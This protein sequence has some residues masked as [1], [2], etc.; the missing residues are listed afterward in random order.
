MKNVSL[1]S[2][3]LLAGACATRPATYDYSYGFSSSR[4]PAQNIS[5]DQLVRFGAEMT[6]GSEELL[7]K[8]PTH[9]VVVETPYSHALIQRIEK[10]LRDALGNNAVIS[11]KNFHSHWSRYA[12]SVLFKDGFE[13]SFFS[14]PGVLEV[15]TNPSSLK[16]IVANEQSI[17][18]YIFESMKKE[19]LT[20]QLF[21]G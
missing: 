5:F 20:P 4:A 21:A 8:F 18:K 17:Q 19:G 1:M 10:N 13:F 16:T 9:Q 3:L 11:T 6:F 12:V 7:S 2:L 14:D 15:N